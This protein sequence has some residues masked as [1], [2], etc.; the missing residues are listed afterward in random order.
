MYLFDCELEIQD[1]DYL[2]KMGINKNDCINK[3][4]EL[5]TFG[6]VN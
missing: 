5:N 3:L 4:D 1:E 6:V 2:L